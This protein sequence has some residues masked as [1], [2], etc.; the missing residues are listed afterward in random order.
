M[1]VLD[2]SHNQLSGHL[3][4][5][6]WYLP[7]IAEA[8]FQGN[9]IKGSR[10]ELFG[11]YKA[12]APIQNI[13]L[14]ENRLTHVVE[15][16]S[17]LGLLREIH[18]ISNAF[19]GKFPNKLTNINK[20]KVLHVSYNS[21]VIGYL[22]YDIG[23]MSNLQ[24]IKLSYTSLR[25]ILTLEIGNLSLFQY[26]GI[27]ET[28][29]K[30]PLPE[31]DGGLNQIFYFSIQ[32]NEADSSKHTDPLPSFS[33]LVNLR[34]LYLNVNIITGSIPYNF[35]VN[36]I[37]MENLVTVG[38]NNNNLT[39]EFS[40]EIDRFKKIHIDFQVDKLSNL[41]EEMFKMKKC[42]SGMVGTF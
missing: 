6:L 15:I 12:T 16:L 11:E 28:Q 7:H 13:L 38:L 8:N 1:T 34:E 36:A 26:L 5:S 25:D 30:V 18:L 19:E 24:D 9:T 39:G 29:L 14:S 3:H 37:T 4:K 27:Y 20:L 32:N 33:D 17:A 40:A 23:N 10:F 21:G 22:L 2:L 31:E 42:N 41:A 35:L